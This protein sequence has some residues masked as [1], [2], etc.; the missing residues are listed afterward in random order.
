MSVPSQTVSAVDPGSKRDL[1]AA[2]KNPYSIANPL[3]ANRDTLSVP[4]VYTFASLYNMATRSYN[5]RWDEAYKNSQA[6]AL[7]MR[8]DCFLQGLLLQRVLPT[9]MMNWNIVSED[10]L[11]PAQK[12]ACKKYEKAIHKIPRFRRYL[13][14][15]MDAVWYGRAGVQQQ[16]GVRQVD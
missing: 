8:R 14:A 11:D 6:N 10:P 16:W 7:S 3:T 5:W 13:K 1:D 4:N 12:D 2:N 15:A 9:V